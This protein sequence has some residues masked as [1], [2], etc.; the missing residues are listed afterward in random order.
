M[1][2][3]DTQ[4]LLLAITHLMQE[5]REQPNLTARRSILSK[6]AKVSKVYKV[7]KRLNE[8]S[9]QH[10]RKYWVRP[11]FTT[12]RRQRQGA[13]DNLLR[14]LEKED[15]DKFYNYLRVSPEQF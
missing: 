4:K 10:H 12:D 7:V 2:K 13:S 3:M 5:L 1:Y 8:N 9:G 11:I 15:E 6:I 14:E